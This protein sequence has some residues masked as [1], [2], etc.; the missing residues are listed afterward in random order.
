[1]KNGAL[2]LIALCRCRATRRWRPGVVSDGRDYSTRH[3]ALSRSSRALGDER[4][5]LSPSFSTGDSMHIHIGKAYGIHS[6]AGEARAPTKWETYDPV[7][8]KNYYRYRPLPVA[9]R[10]I[11][12]VSEV[13]ML[14]LWHWI[15]KDIQKRA[16]KLRRSMI[17]LGP[18]YIKLGQALSTRPDILPNAYCLE[19]AKLQDRIPPFPTPDALRFFEGQ[20]GLPASKVFAEISEKPIAAAS[21]GQVY[22]ARLHTGEAVAVKIQRPGV[23]DVLALDGHL[24]RW[25]G[26]QLQGFAG[27]R[28]DLVAVVDEMVRHMFEEV[29]YLREGDN[30]ERFASLFG[31][32]TH[33]SNPFHPSP[34]MEYCRPFDK[35]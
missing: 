4:L 29:D 9:F 13:F 17:R 8:F 28:G 25:L 23:R 11:T 12:I 32:R 20:F 22:K 5:F 16:D 26:G 35:F 33:S 10:A 31:L 34:T 21:L 18:F 7:A 3:H 14:T 15:E 24:L 30:A 2:H 19:L 27:A 6:V 1:M